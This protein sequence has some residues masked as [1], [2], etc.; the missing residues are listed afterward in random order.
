MSS[1]STILA[2]LTPAQHEAATRPGPLLVLAGAGTGK[3]RT[4]TAAAAHRI[5]VR[6]IPP[7]RLLAVTFTNKAAAEMV[8]RIRA[9][10]GEA[11][12]PRWIGT[13]HGLGARQLRADPDLAGLRPDFGI[14]DAEDSRRLLRRVLK[15]AGLVEALP[16]DGRRDP[17]KRLADRISRWKDRLLSPDRAARDVD[18]AIA[19][20]RA[21]RGPWVEEDVARA[22]LRA[23]AACQAALREANAA[24]FGDLLLWPTLAMMADRG[25]RAAWARRFDCVL[26]DEYQDTNPAQERWLDCTASA[27]TDLVCVGDDSQSIFGWRGANIDGIRGFAR[28]R[29]G[30][31]VLALE[32][33]FR[34]TGHILDAANAIIA[35]DR[36]RLPKQLF[37]RA[38]PGDRVEVL[39]F[40]EADAEADGIA[41]EIQRRNRAGLP[42]EAFAILY[43]ANALS[44]AL[45]EALIRAKV[46]Y[47]VVGDVGFWQRAEVKDAL[48]FLRLSESPDDPLGN[49]AFRRVV[50]TPPRGL[51]DRT[52]EEI[53]AHA[54]WRRVSL[55]IAVETADLPPRARAAALAF[56]DAVRSAVPRQGEAVAGRLSLLLKR[57]GYRQW[58]RGS[59]AEGSEARLENVAELIDLAGQFHSAAELLDHAALATAAPGE[60]EAA[61]VRLMTMHRAKG[62]EFPHAF[63]PAWEEGLF[64]SP[65]AEDDSEERRLAYVGITRGM[66]RVTITHA[67]WRRGRTR[68]SPFLADL[69][70]G[71][72]H[73]GWIDNPARPPR[74]APAPTTATAEL[75]ALLGGGTTR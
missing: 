32:E 62:L 40:T 74:Y 59:A 12:T 60:D 51:G 44:R 53:E 17:M 26:V 73:D 58:L 61:R 19:A 54:A 1:P 71:T 67:A 49:E 27:T 31:A 47:V 35:R 14:L 64:P 72:W 37:T 10:L 20:S 6:G 22:E 50:N 70:A 48:A 28:R 55:L 69:P 41:A 33:N 13:F 23:Y 66:R 21:Q 75:D 15:E 30:A 5:A 29:P 39:R 18:E 16:E 36:G 45:E 43:R 34:S 56:A 3:T 63:L 42:W 65:L 8:G 57:T 11:R 9:A 24:D 52:V 68:P 25:A 38:G 2:G 46:P 7:G 4:L